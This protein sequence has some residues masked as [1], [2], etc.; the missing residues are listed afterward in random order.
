MNYSQ[1]ILLENVTTF[2]ER[3]EVLAMTEA[4]TMSADKVMVNKLFDTIMSKSNMDFGSIPESKGRVNKFSGY[5]SMVESLNVIDSLAQSKLKNLK[6]VQV[7]QNALGN[8]TTNTDIFEKGFKFDVEFIKVL[9][10]TLVTSCLR[11]TSNIIDGYIDFIKGPVS[12][13]LVISQSFDSDNTK[14]FR[15]LEEFNNSCKNGTFRKTLLGYFEGDRK[16]F[17]GAAIGT[18]IA[19]GMAVAGGLTMIVP[20]LRELVY[21]IFYSRMKISQ[22]LEHQALF[23]EAN[24]EALEINSNIPDNKRNKVIESQ[25]KT[26]DKLRK[27]SDMIRVDYATSTSQSEKEIKNANRSWTLGGVKSEND[28]TQTYSI[29]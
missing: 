14:I 23:L 5:A 27:L 17:T 9:Y 6:E 3:R 21:L 1:K 15:L 11:A 26:I 25:R 2:S 20:L 8:I 18:S 22:F 16:N 12:S 10:N 13:Q 4:E 29:F 7:V 24:K 19:V 28:A